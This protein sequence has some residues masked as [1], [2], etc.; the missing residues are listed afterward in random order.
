MRK[1]ILILFLIATAYYGYSQATWVN[2]PEIEEMERDI[3][4]VW[5][6]LI[7]TSVVLDITNENR[8]SLPERL[9]IEQEGQDMI[10]TRLKR[11]RSSTAEFFTCEKSVDP[12]TEIAWE[13]R[14]EMEKG[15]ARIMQGPKGEDY[16]VMH[17]KNGNVEDWRILH[18]DCKTLILTRTIEYRDLSGDKRSLETITY[19]RT[20]INVEGAIKLLSE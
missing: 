13:N 7:K 11:G 18:M 2:L 15:T 6:L 4:G 17:Q 14:R 9:N 1:S 8:T 3:D 10:A 20:D 16:I 19:T 12:A 5:L